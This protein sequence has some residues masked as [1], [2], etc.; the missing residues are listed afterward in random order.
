MKKHR[1]TWDY[2]IE[3]A[4]QNSKLSQQE[5]L[6]LMAALRFFKAELGKGFLKSTVRNHPMQQIIF[7]AVAAEANDL[8][9]YY[10]TLKRLKTSA[11]NYDGLI[12]K[13]RRED[14]CRK[15]GIP[16]IEVVDLLNAHDCQLEFVKENN[17][18]GQKHA[19]ILLTHVNS[20]IEI[21][22]EV[23]RLGESDFR[24]ANSRNFH[25]IDELFNHTPPYLPYSLK[26]L[27]D[28]P[29]DESDQVIEQLSNLKSNIDTS[30][31]QIKCY[32][33]GYV[34]LMITSENNRESFEQQCLK[35]NRKIGYNSIEVDFN[36]T[37][38]VTRK[39]REEA[40]QIPLLTAGLVV[41]KTLPLYFLSFV[42]SLSSS[43][44][45]IERE[46]EKRPQIAGLIVFGEMHID[47][48]H[49]E[50]SWSCGHILR[51]RKVTPY[52]TQAIL[53]VKNEAFIHTKKHS[54]WKWI[55]DSLD[56]S[57]HESDEAG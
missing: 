10:R 50:I 3:Y 46:L 43:F 1:K 25:E 18:Q 28:I 53:Y 2:H 29:E 41:I 40:K 15:E 9:S 27:Q 54:V 22:I 30:S 24:K 11:I 55:E 12:N 26:Q 47:L 7:N 44:N 56:T 49:K 42:Q 20:D 4:K 51:T 5:G 6:E 32:T 52:T 23:S 21:I 8:I 39:L 48:G 31:K 34:D 45:A 38:R 35:L 33:D 19:D 37:S 16:F 17:V 36:D 14:D 13:F 57:L